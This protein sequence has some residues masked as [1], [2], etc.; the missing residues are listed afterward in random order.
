[1]SGW[2]TPPTA[3]ELRRMAD[4]MS[5]TFRPSVTGC[6]KCGETKNLAKDGACRKPI[7]C[8]EWAV[9]ARVAALKERR[10]TSK[11]DRHA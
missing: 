2:I 1:M 8:F 7:P 5:L 3:E 11:D 6:S 4:P 10:E 9:K